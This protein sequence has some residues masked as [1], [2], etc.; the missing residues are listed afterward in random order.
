MQAWSTR[1]HVD[2]HPLKWDWRDMAYT[3]GSMLRAAGRDK[4]P[5]RIGAAVYVPAHGDRAATSYLVA[6]GGEGPSW[7]ITRAELAAIHT[8]ALSKGHTTICTD[9]LASIRMIQAA[10]CDPM[11]LHRHK[12]RTLL[13]EI[14]ALIDAAQTQVT[15]AKVAAHQGLGAM[16]A[17]GNNE[18]DTAAKEAARQEEEAC[19][20]RCKAEAH[21]FSDQVWIRVR[22]ENPTD[23]TSKLV[24]WGT[25]GRTSRNKCRQC[26]G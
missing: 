2:R 10:V 1:E 17:I 11:R 5:G 16:G 7:T 22:T 12:H 3:D 23:G 4:S 24:M 25:C 26:T 8:A 14:V 9:S 21:G 18:A 19:D 13:E 15:I 6:P 20:I